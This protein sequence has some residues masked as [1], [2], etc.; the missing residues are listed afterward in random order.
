MKVETLDMMK[1]YGVPL[2][3]NVD[4]RGEEIWEI[5]NLAMEKDIREGVISNLLDVQ[6][7]LTMEKNLELI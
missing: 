6:I 2:L 5:L 3:H 7:T 1:R 4:M